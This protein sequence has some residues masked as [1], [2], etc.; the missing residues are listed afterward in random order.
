MLGLQKIAE[1]GGRP[2]PDIFKDPG[3]VKGVTFDL[4]TSQVRR[5][6]LNSGKLLEAYLASLSSSQ[7]QI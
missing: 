3:F 4:S 6:L 5:D 7:P 1:E 2:A